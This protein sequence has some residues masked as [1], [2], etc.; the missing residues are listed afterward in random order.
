VP[1]NLTFVLIFLGRLLLGGH[2]LIS[3]IRNI[4]N[5]ALNT[6]MITARG[7]PQPRLALFA[8]II[9]E[10]VAGALVAFGIW[11]ALG[12]VGLIVFSVAAAVL[13]HNFWDYKGEERITHI[14]A[15]LT[16]AALI[17]G[18]LLVVAAR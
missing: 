18:L 4:G 7:V 14:N 1:T 12:A 2:F 8:G 11:P 5:I 6:Q 10:A 17:G 13:Y 15:C 3:A 16:N 9:L